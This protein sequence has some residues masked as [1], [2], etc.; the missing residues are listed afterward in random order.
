LIFDLPKNI[1]L[2]FLASNVSLNYAQE[3]GSRVV[4][5]AI[6]AYTPWPGKSKDLLIVTPLMHRNAEEAR[7]Q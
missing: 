4:V 5:R 6:R 7:Y 2:A 3:R 1:I